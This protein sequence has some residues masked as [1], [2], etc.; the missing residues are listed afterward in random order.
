MNSVSKLSSEAS[1]QPLLQ[2]PLQTILQTPKQTTSQTFQVAI[3]GAECTGKTALMDSLVQY[4]ALASRFFIQ[5]LPELL[6][7]F[8]EQHG[9]TP[10]QQ[11]QLSLFDAQCRSLEKSRLLTM[12]PLSKPTLVISDCGPITTALYSE[13]IF[14]DSSLLDQAT[15]FHRQQIDLHFV[16]EPEFEWS[17]DPLPFMRDGVAAQTQ[18]AE[19][20]NQWIDA[21]TGI[22]WVRLSGSPQQRLERASAAIVATYAR[23]PA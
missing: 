14:N 17:A 7:V 15:L 6:R 5:V 18:F 19:R 11:E 1:L 22:V 23:G 8:C 16:L 2:A 20:L 13:L 4:D 3:L 12:A 10:T 9:R 21:T